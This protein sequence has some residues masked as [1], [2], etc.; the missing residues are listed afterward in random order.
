VDGNSPDAALMAGPIDDRVEIG[1][2][3][4]DKVDPPR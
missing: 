1:L 3:L 4:P 2:Q